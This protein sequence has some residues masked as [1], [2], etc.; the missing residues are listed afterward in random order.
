MKTSD[1]IAKIAPAL[2]NAQKAI[3]FATKDAM[4]P[5]LKNR[6]A[7]LQSVIEAIKPALNDAGIVFMQSATPSS[8]EKLHLVTRMIHESGEWI[9]D[10]IVIPVVKQDAQGHGSALTYARRYSLASMTGLFQ[11]DDDGNEVSIGK[12]NQ[13]P[14]KTEPTGIRENELEDIKIAMREAE[15]EQ[16]LLR[17]GSGVPANA[18]DAQKAELSGEYS[19]RR[20]ALKAAQEA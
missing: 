13:K 17:I 6:Y 15:D 20:K 8:D 19:K 18:T 14:A 1:S 12:A 10:E 11:S 3:T 16:A 4:N 9:E 7:D 5:H 2:L